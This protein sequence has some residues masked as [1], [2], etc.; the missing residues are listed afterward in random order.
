MEELK[1][2]FSYT[3]KDSEFVLK[4]AK[5]LRAVG[6]NLWLDQLDIL[7]GQH[8]DSTVEK[9]LKSCKGM[10]A[11]LSPESVASDNVM[12][13]V[14]YALDEGKLVVPVVIRSCDIPLR[15]R[16]VQYIDFTADYDTGFSQLLRALGIEQ[17]V[18][19]LESTATQE[20][21]VQEP[22]L[23]KQPE[24]TP[25]EQQIGLETEKAGSKS[26][27]TKM[28]A[29][30]CIVALIA[31]V[32]TGVFLKYLQPK[33]YSLTAT[34]V[35][36]SITKSPD[37]AS[38][39]NGET[40]TLEA[41]PNP[42]Y[43][44]KNWSGELAGSTNPA[45]LVMDADKSVT[46]SFTLKTYSLTATAVDGS[47]TKSPDK[48][49]YNH[50]E[51]VTLE[52]ISE[53]GYSVT[54]W[55][56]DLSGSTNPATLVMDVDKSVTASFSP[57]EGD[58]AT[59]SI[60][61]K[62]VYIP[63]GS[64]LMGS[65]SS[66]AQLAREYDAPEESFT[67]EF[68]QHQ[69]RISEG[70]WMG[71]TEVTQGQY[72]S[73]MN[74]Q[75]W[76]R[77]PRV[78]EDANNPAAYMT[79]EDAAVFCRKLSQQEGKTYRLPTE[80]EWEYACRAGTTTRFSSGD[81]DSS[82]DEYAW[83]SGNSSNTMHPFGQKRVNAFD[84]YD[85]HGNVKEWCSDWYDEDYYSNS[86]SVDPNGPPTGASHSLRGG[87][88]NWPEGGLRSSYR[89]HYYPVYRGDNVGFRVVHSKS[90]PHVEP[91]RGPERPEVAAEEPVEA[92]PLPK[93]GD[94][95]TNSIGM[96]LIY[97]PA[98]SFVM[99]SRH[100][101]AQLTKEYNQ[102]EGY[103]ASEFPQHQ[104]RICEGFWM[105]QTEVTQGQYKSVMNAQPWSRNPVVE[106]SANNPAIWVTWEDAA[107]FCRKL[108][109]QE[110][111]TYRLP[112]EA[113]WEYTCRA[114]TT[115][116]F[117]FG[118]S[119]SSLG[120]YAWFE[121][122][123]MFVDQK[124]AHAVG[125]KKPNPWGMYDMHGNVWEWCSDWYKEDYYAQAHRDNP[126]G[127]TTGTSRSLRG[128]AWNH[129]GEDLRCSYRRYSSPGGRHLNVG[130]RVVRSQ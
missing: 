120:D 3:R 48:T 71:Q 119:S 56:G 100:S 76:S 102:K 29:A 81:S 39:N 99:G 126:K 105:G 42:G 32:S 58:V 80:A 112:T 83:Y 20:P 97:I 27:K 47:V 15:L 33:T 40:V 92:A 77:Q 117:S 95:V 22:S 59:N 6:A 121:N 52:A 44:F 8:W 78:Q 24:P 30:I 36:G 113:E 43:S 60:G 75:P 111:K 17:N 49:R 68:P 94:V 19:P 70:F 74:V 108:S 109:Q 16:R 54:N 26:Q 115:T 46:A 98:G 14:S 38:Y 96:K 110:G 18:Q 85:M 57:K 5:E 116:R 25:D 104:V 69:V 86:P 103:F 2:F 79:W 12:D 28:L 34:A 13:E 66:A 67:D 4:L 64:F 45:T 125:Q 7:G 122:N 10:I 9:A 106:E 127:P 91:D 130:F 89:N 53:R 50:G 114:G 118:D 82:L 65:S 129:G 84:L 73:V 87:S 123:A 1:Y 88:W 31:I 107:A 35:D 128:G 55:S 93:P 62:L 72:K 90:G 101:E 11:V 63:A 124:Y 37:Q 61:M 23:P 21:V 51:E 41:V